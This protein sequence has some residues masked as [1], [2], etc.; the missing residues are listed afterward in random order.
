MPAPDRCRS[1]RRGNAGLL[2]ERLPDLLA[3]EKG[4]QRGPIEDFLG[5]IGLDRRR[6]VKLQRPSRKVQHQIAAEQPVLRMLDDR[7]KP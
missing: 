1:S 2:D 3:V 6:A 4:L 5:P 7:Q